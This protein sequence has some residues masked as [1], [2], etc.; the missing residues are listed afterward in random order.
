MQFAE[1]N[2]LNSLM[3]PGLIFLSILEVFFYCC[4][5]FNSS[6]VLGEINA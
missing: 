3:P 1:L 6:L 4:K 5:D 2:L